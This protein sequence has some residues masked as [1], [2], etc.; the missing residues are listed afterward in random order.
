MT[1]QLRVAAYFGIGSGINPS[2][3]D[4]PASIVSGGWE[5]HVAEVLTPGTLAL[6][7]NVRALTPGAG[8]TIQQ[9]IEDCVWWTPWGKPQNPGQPDH[10]RLDFCQLLQAR[11]ARLWTAARVGDFRRAVRQYRAACGVSRLWLYLGRFEHPRWANVRN[12]AKFASL[13]RACVEPL[14][15]ETGVGV[16]I[17]AAGPLD[18]ERDPSFEALAILAREGINIGWEG[19][20]VG[21]ETL[22]VKSNC[23]QTMT[24]PGLKCM[25]FDTHATFGIGLNY[26]AIDPNSIA[27]DKYVLVKTLT[28]NAATLAGWVNDYGIRLAVSAYPGFDAGFSATF[29]GNVRNELNNITK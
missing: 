26:W 28:P 1:V 20:A 10:L 19:S 7:G 2:A 23:W 6:R 8:F 3:R 14:L 15:G 4:I 9:D 25:Q 16:M 22:A 21:G 17:D 12:G 11:A 5:K 18:T 13:V 24:R 27:A 29:L